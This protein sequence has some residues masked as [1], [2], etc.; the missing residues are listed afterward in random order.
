[1]TPVSESEDE[2]KGESPAP[3]DAGQDEEDELFKTPL[4]C[5]ASKGAALLEALESMGN[6]WRSQT[7]QPA[8]MPSK[9]E[10]TILRM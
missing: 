9:N 2:G 4:S 10:S 7:A 8:T 1:M 5:H 3:S 6:S